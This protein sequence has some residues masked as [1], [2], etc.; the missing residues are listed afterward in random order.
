VAIENYGCA[1]R[2]VE[3]TREG[4]SRETVENL[5]P[6]GGGEK[7]GQTA[8]LKAIVDGGKVH[9]RVDVLKVFSTRS[10]AKISSTNGLKL[11]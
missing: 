6:A 8:T 11:E 10:D 9:R 3:E 5:R 4:D 1:G 7:V 2:K